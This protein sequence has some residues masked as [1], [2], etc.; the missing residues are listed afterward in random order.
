MKFDNHPGLHGD[1][2]LHIPMP[3]VSGTPSECLMSLSYA[4][5]DASD[6][7]ALGSPLSVDTATPGSEKI[8]VSSSTAGDAGIF[9]VLV[10]ITDGLSSVDNT[11]EVFTVTAHSQATAIVVTTDNVSAGS[12]YTHSIGDLQGSPQSL[13][14]PVYSV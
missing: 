14:L 12:P 5:E 4:I 2:G 8:V 6:G 7:S 1:W 3:T 13:T 10:R 11:D 9:N